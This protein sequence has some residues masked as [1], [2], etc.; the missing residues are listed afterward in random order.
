LQQAVESL[1]HEAAGAVSGL[2]AAFRSEAGVLAAAARRV[3]HTLSR[4]GV[5]TGALDL[6]RAGG[7]RTGDH[8]DVLLNQELLREAVWSAVGASHGGACTGDEASE[9]TADDGEENDGDFSVPAPCVRSREKVVSRLSSM[10]EAGLRRMSA[11]GGSAWD[12]E[13]EVARRVWE[14]EMRTT[15]RGD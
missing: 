3:V 6:Y 10:S 12:G 5:V 14:G 7:G 9:V 4:E 11:A 2:G 13:Y 1:Q 8:V 15:F